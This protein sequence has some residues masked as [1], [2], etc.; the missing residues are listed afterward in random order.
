MINMQ[1]FFTPKLFIYLIYSKL[2]TLLY[3]KLVS[4]RFN[5]NSN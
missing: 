5:D 4:K 2:N 3:I 1:C